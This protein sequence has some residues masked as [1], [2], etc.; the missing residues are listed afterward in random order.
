MTDSDKNK[1]LSLVNTNVKLIAH[2]GYSGRY[3]ENTLLS[4][5]A[6][7]T[8]GARLMEIDLQMTSDVESVLHHDVSLKRMAGVDLD[9]R[10]TSTS[11]FKALKAGYS[12]RFTGE[13]ADN[14]FTTFDEFCQWLV[15]Y[16][17]VTVF[18]EL[19][20]E[21][22]DYF[23]LEVFM[24]DVYRRLTTNGV[25]NQC[26]IISFNYKILEYSRKLSTVPIGWVLPKWNDTFKGIAE[27][28]NPEYLF[29]GTH[30]LPEQ[31]SEIWSGTWQWAIYN[32][33]DVT[34]AI[35]MANRGIPFLETNQ[36]GTLL[37]DQRFNALD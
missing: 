24:D 34:S 16:P 9:V 23:G 35:N 15:K 26:V 5:E 27:R 20:Q 22:I 4:Y 30:I 13:F 3:P 12:E 33:D 6:A 21:S 8:H 28:L 14:T 2:R 29:S 17:E 11:N 1:G 7:Y 36:I 18:V 19:K 31:D 10:E 32:L 37:S 25:E